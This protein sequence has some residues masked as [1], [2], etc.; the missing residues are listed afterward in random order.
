MSHRLEKGDKVRG[1]GGFSGEIQKLVPGAS[2]ELRVGP[3][4]ITFHESMLLLE[5]PMNWKIGDV[6]RNTVSGVE[7]RIVHVFSDRT[8]KTQFGYI[9]KPGLVW[10]LIE[11]PGVR[12]YRP[13]GSSTSAPSKC[14]ECRGTGYVELFTSKVRCS[15]G[16]TP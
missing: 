15:R 13:E 7:D 2:Y 8:A 12:V 4:T 11:R 14:P 1:S 5:C 9:G 16:C 6:V 3:Q 10:Q